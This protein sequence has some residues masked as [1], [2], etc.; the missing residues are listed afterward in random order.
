VIGHKSVKAMETCIQ[1]GVESLGRT[2]VSYFTSG[3][4]VAIGFIIK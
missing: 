1:H 2:P 3:V 4:G